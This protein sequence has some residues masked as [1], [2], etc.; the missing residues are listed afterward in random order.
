[1]FKLLDLFCCAGGAGEGY[2]LAGFDVTGIDIEPQP[3]NPHRFIQADALEYLSKHWEEYNAIHASPPCQAY[4][5]ANNQ[6]KGKRS[7]PDLIGATRD[8]LVKTNKLWVIENVPN[9]PIRKDLFLNGSTF[10]IK[11]HRPRIFEMNFEIDQPEVPFITPLKMGRKP[12]DGDII[13]PVGHFSGVKY[14]A[15]EMGLPWMHQY[16]LSQAIPPA[17]TKYIGETMFNILKSCG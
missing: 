3:K 1:M 2:R 5:K 17:Y 13:Q 9:S 16:E 14:A 10:G 6:W 4:S 15:K 8:L 12:K 7:Y 11:V